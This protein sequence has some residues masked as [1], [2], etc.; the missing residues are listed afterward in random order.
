M[1]EII[2]PVYKGFVETK[3]CIQSVLN[4]NGIDEFKLIIIDDCSPDFEIKK[5]LSRLQDKKNIEVYT[6]KK[7]LGFVQ[8]VNKG[9]TL[10]NSDVILL[11]SDVIVSKNALCNMVLVGN[12]QAA[13]ATVTALTNRGTISSVPYYNQDSELLNRF[14]IETFALLMQEMSEK[15]YEVVPTCVGHCVWIKREVIKKIGFF[16]DKT[17]KKGYGEENDF[18][19]RVINEGYKNVVALKSFVYHYGSTSFAQEKEKMVNENKYKL[20]R[21]HPSYFFRVKKFI[22]CNNEI[23][24]MC[25]KIQIKINHMG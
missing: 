5:Y 11:N 14:S 17:F 18:S 22:W 8:T 1:L 6:N 19:M 20:Y 13:I 21:K 12:S 3:K 23:K 24:K 7:N 4:S 16:D 2:I 25:K 9:L 15:E 10:T